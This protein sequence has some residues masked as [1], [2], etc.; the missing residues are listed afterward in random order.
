[1]KKNGNDIVSPLDFTDVFPAC[2]LHMRFAN[3]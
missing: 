3:I 1:M 2:P